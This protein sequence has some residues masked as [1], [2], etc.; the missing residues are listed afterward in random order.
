MKVMEKILKS[1]MLKFEML[2]FNMFKFNMLKSDTLNLV[3]KKLF[4][5]KKNINTSS[6]YD[7][8][9]EYCM[10]NNSSHFTI[11]NSSSTCWPSIKYQGGV[12]KI[13]INEDIFY[14]IKIKSD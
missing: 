12:F 14:L 3:E 13:I 11:D 5:T 7:P 6:V 2:E 4:G 10:A 8:Y 1:T 9:K